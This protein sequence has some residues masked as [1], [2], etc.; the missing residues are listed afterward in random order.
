MAQPL[1]QLLK[2][3]M[4]FRF[5]PICLMAEAEAEAAMP[6]KPQQQWLVATVGVME[7]AAAVVA[8]GRNLQ[9]ALAATERRASWL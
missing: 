4:G 2:G 3:K 6:A 9:A 1:A 7:L 5:Q 8:L